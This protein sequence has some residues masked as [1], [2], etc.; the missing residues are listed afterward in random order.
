MFLDEFLG[1]GESSLFGNNDYDVDMS[2]IE[3]IP[4]REGE[5]PLDACLRITIENEQNYTNIVSTIALSEL[6]A[7]EESGG[8]EV[9]Y[10]AVD[11]KKIANSIGAWIQKQWA[12]LK[13][14]FQRA[15][16]NLRTMI[17]SDK[18]LI[19]KYEENKDKIKSSTV[20]V[21][22]VKLKKDMLGLAKT[23]GEA[24][25]AEFNSVANKID[26]SNLSSITPAK[27]DAI[28]KDYSDNKD[29]MLREA[30]RKVAGVNSTMADFAKN[31]KKEYCEIGD[32]D[33]DVSKAYETIKN[34][35]KIKDLVKKEFKAAQDE[36]KKEI[37]D[38][39]KMK[40]DYKGDNHSAVAKVINVKTSQIRTKITHLNLLSRAA[41]QICKAHYD[42]NKKALVVALSGKNIEKE[43]NKETVNGESALICDLI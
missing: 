38:A 16:D 15:F 13:G 6:A 23:F 26:L 30:M 5:D 4:V 18:K 11:I 40:K 34:E 28:S 7:L 8:T 10:E 27:A 12:K 42:T 35:T 20:T 29:I 33:I 41:L 9:V 17:S 39:N 21:R 43:D 19:K 31:V 3:A 25:D 14:V 22:G 24:L 1:L 2:Q 32:V 37:A 36:F